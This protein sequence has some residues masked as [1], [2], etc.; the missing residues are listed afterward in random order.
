M[1][2]SLLW[3]SCSRDQDVMWG[4][5]YSMQFQTED[6]HGGKNHLCVIFKVSNP[7]WHEWALLAPRSRQVEWR[8]GGHNSL[9]QRQIAGGSSHKPGGD[10]YRKRT[11]FYSSQC[12]W[13]P[14]DSLLLQT[15]A[16]WLSWHSC[17][18]TPVDEQEQSKHE[19]NIVSQSF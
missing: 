16:P 9:T 11:V 18:M 4:T 12:V 14:G 3:S 7:S 17:V 5:P 2:P 1:I 15:V 13:C 19:M 6:S 10:G 8:G